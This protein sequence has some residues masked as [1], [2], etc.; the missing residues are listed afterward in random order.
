[1]DSARFQNII[2]L[3]GTLKATAAIV[4]NRLVTFTGT[5][6][7]AADRVRG[8]AGT[9]AAIGEHFP[10][11]EIGELAIESGAAIAVGAP[12]GA[13]ASGCAVTVA[14]GDISRIGFALTAVDGPGKP[15]IV[16]TR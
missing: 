16:L 4:A 1:M 2:I 12:V 10:V 9:Q 11:N 3:A 15:V 6:A 8:V 14:A 13:D 7:T 5:Q